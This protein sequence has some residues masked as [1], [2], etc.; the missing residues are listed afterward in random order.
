[1]KSRAGGSREDL[2][3]PYSWLMRYCI[4]VRGRWMYSRESITRLI[5]LARS[6]VLRLDA[7]VT[8]FELAQ[9]N[10]T[11]AHA[12]AHAAPFEAPVICPSAS[13][14]L[15]TLLPEHAYSSSED[16]QH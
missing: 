4:T 5:A 12:A 2:A 16:A 7:R 11:I 13:H 15:A 3:L 8:S 14:S 6:G 9:V 1:M 10:E